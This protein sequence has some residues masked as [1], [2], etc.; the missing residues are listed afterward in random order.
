MPRPTITW[1]IVLANAGQLQEAIEHYQ[2]ALRL[3]PDYAEAH[4]NL[5]TA[6]VD[7]GRPQEAIEHYRQALRLNPDYP[8]A[9]NNLGAALANAGQLQEAIEHYKQA[10]R[11]KPDYTY[12]LLQFG[13]GLCQD[14]AVLRGHCRGPEGLGT[15]PLPGAGGTGQKD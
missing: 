2:Q 10:L 11:L 5:G 3:K 15:C 6:L 13:F 1:A 4:N 9:H 7:T 12:A 14:A 8:E